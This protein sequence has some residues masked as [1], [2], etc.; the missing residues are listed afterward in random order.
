MKH[1]Y[2]IDTDCHNEGFKVIC[3]KGVYYAET[4]GQLKMFLTLCGVQDFVKQ[5]KE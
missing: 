1:E 3:E 4:V 5:L 2:K